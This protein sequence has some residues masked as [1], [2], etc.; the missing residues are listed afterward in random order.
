MN[1]YV[2]IK[3]ETALISKSAQIDRLKTL[4]IIL[5]LNILTTLCNPYGF[6]LYSYITNYLFKTNAIL[7]A[8]DEFLSPIFHGALQP[9]L[10]ETFFALFVIGLVINK[11]K[12]RLPD[13]CIYI[14]FAH[15]SLSAQRNMALYVIVALP[16][17]ARLYANTILSPTQGAL[18]QN[19]NTYWRLLITKFQNMNENFTNTEKLCNTHLL[20]IIV[21]VVMV[22]IAV[23]GDR[24]VWFQY[25]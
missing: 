4:S 9:F 1:I 17:I 23:N 10:L 20:P 14:I 18:Y 16:I 3:G 2:W 8:T 25:Y 24:V 13:L 7:S 6:E 15:L 22:C 19:L 12:I 11:G 5:G 21:F